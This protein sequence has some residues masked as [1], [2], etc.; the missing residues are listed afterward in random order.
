MEAAMAQP[1]KPRR[2]F[3]RYE[4]DDVSATM[5]LAAMLSAAAILGVIAYHYQ[6]SPETAER[7]ALERSAP[8]NPGAR[9]LGTSG[10]GVPAPSPSPQR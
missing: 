3:G 4:Y 9:P 7:A 8:T 10:S 2:R 6:G 1:I 5:I